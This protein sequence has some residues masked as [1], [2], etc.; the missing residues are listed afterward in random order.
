MKSEKHNKLDAY[1]ERNK[2]RDYKELAQVIMEA[3]K[4]QNLQPASWK[5][6]KAKSVVP[7]PA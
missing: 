4:S 5:C 6:W 1:R 2:E 3:K 7:L